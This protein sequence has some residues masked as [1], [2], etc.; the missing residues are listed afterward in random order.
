MKEPSEEEKAF[1]AKEASKPTVRGA[2]TISKWQPEFDAWAL[3]VELSEQAA[4]VLGGDMSR[5]EVMLLSQAHTLDAL[6]NSLAEK[7][8][9]QTGLTQFE[10]MLRLALKAQSQCRATLETLSN[11]K[12]PPVIYAKQ[13]N[14]SNGHQ[15]INNS[16]SAPHA[17]ETKNMPNE[18]LEHTHGERLDTR[19][20]G[21]TI[22]VNTAMETLGEIHGGADSRG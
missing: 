1:L 11:I 22:R 20:Q 12:N 17:G 4:K 5:P 3:R 8:K 18:L 7:A 6:F 9:D 2:L 16:I 10:T 15:Q 13:A 21:E 14:F 19:A